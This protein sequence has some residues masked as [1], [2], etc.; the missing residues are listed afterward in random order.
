MLADARGVPE[1]WRFAASAQRIEQEYLSRDRA[2]RKKTWVRGSL[3]YPPAPLNAEHLR[4]LTQTPEARMRGHL[5]S[6]SD[7]SERG[8]MNREQGSKLWQLIKADT[9]ILPINLGGGF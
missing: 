2:R 3:G 7:L 8:P 9:F 1:R 5:R 4:T 6:I